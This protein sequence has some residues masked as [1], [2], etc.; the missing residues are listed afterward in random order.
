MLFADGVWYRGR[1]VARV[2]HT[3]PPRWRVHFEDGET[4]D[5]IL[6]ASPYSPVRFDASAYG[7]RVEVRFGG[8]WYRGRL[9][10]LLRGSEA[11]GVEFEDWDWAEDVR[12]GD[13]GVRYVFSLG[14]EGGG[15][16]G[17]KREREEGVEESSRSSLPGGVEGVGGSDTHAA[18]TVQRERGAGNEAQGRSGESGGRAEGAYGK[19]FARGGNL[20][21][22]MRTHTCEK[23][24]N[25]ETCGQAFTTSGSLATH[26]RTHTGE[27]PYVCETCGRAFSESG[28]M[29]THMRTHTGERPYVCE[30]CSKAFTTS[31]NLSTHMRTHTGERPYV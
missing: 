30:T 22:H 17:T 25:C 15:G 12:L 31:G 8:E 6:L 10:E 2:P 14:E 20:A 19:A 21:A 7:A 27:R 4:R 13:P 5:D 28:Q 24:Y 9:V 18:T 3:D 1:L 29:A 26:M 23:P 16:G 11:W